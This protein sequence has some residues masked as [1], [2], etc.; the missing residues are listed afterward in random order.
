MYAFGVL[1]LELLSGQHGA[2]NDEKKLVVT[3]AP[4]L[5]PQ[6][7]K[8]EAFIDERLLGEY[9]VEVAK[10]LAIV[11]KHCVADDPD[12]RPEMSKLVRSL[13]RLKA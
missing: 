1:L 12:S 6:P 2:T 10:K 13:I 3:L 5:R 4:H 7:P 8:V 9:D 11:A